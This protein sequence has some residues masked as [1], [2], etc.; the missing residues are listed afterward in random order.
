MDRA[1]QANRPSIVIKDEKSK[2]SF[3]IDMTMLPTERNISIKEFD[4]LS[5]YKDP[6]VE[7]ERMR[8]LKTTLIPVVVGALG[9]VKRG[10]P[11]PYQII[12]GEP[13]L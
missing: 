6:Q 4:K 13:N 12:H 9:V 5:K 10:N 7:I 8:H 11:E 3:L 2:T 1:I